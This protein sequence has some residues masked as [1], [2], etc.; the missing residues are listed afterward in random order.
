MS[1]AFTDTTIVLCAHISMINRFPY[2]NIYRF[3]VTYTISPFTSTALTERLLRGQG[4]CKGTVADLSHVEIPTSDV[5]PKPIANEATRTYIYISNHE[6][7]MLAN[8]RQVSYPTDSSKS[9]RL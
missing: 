8:W 3:V 7:V 9:T 1:D 6:R 4:L 2:E 5:S